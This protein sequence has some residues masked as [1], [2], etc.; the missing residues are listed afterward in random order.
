MRTAIQDWYEANIMGEA[1][2]R[3]PR[4]K[5]LLCYKIN[6]G[7]TVADQQDPWL[8]TV[9]RQ[10]GFQVTVGRVILIYGIPADSVMEV[11]V[12]SNPPEG[13][14]A[15]EVLA[16]VH[17]RARNEADRVVEELWN[18]RDFSTTPRFRYSN[19]VVA[20]TVQAVL[21]ADHGLDVEVH[22]SAIMINV[23]MYD[24]ASP[25]DSG[26]PPSEEMFGGLEHSY[27]ADAPPP[28]GESISM[29]PSPQHKSPPPSPWLSRASSPSTRL[30]SPLTSAQ[31]STQPSIAHSPAIGTPSRRE[32]DGEI[33]RTEFGGT[34]SEQSVSPSSASGSPMGTRSPS[35]YHCDPFRDVSN[36]N[37]SRSSRSRS[38]FTTS[39]PRSALG[40]HGGQSFISPSR[41]LSPREHSSSRR[42]VSS[43]PFRSPSRE[44]TPPEQPIKVTPSQGRCPLPQHPLR[45]ESSR[46]PSPLPP[47]QRSRS[48]SLPALLCCDP[49]PRSPSPSRLN[50]DP[51]GHL[52]PMSRSSGTSDPPDP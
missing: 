34:R 25:F 40:S 29:Q 32:S 33:Q 45:S 51:S 38:P 24:M 28:A 35:P 48:R 14:W 44:P 8:A 49:L 17:T 31:Q 26:F 47:L 13:S 22:G 30:Q 20:R 18:W 9:L 10:R 46:T 41:S 19:G 23:G 2:S 7:R 37:Y 3:D 50:D 6:T 1:R 21:Q 4:K 43:D 5:D 36:S 16:C 15:A 27:C 39:A 52:T 11:E 12:P 42:S